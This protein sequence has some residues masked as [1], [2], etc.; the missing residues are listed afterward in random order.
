[1]G[2]TLAGLKQF[3]ADIMEKITSNADEQMDVIADVHTDLNT[4]QVLEEGVG[5]PFDI[6]V[7]IGDGPDRRL[8]RGAVFSYY[9]FK[10]PL[11]DRLTD[12]A[13]QKMEAAEKRPDLPGW[14]QSFIVR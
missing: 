11:D 5:L 4:S 9:E 1:M 13:W 7:I 2:R 14:T 3:P 12:E 6:Y 10:W 8:C